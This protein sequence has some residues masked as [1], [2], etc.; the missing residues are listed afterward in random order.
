MRKALNRER[1]NV[2]RPAYTDRVKAILLASTDGGVEERLADALD[3]YRRGTQP[4][5][6]KWAV[7]SARACKIRNRSS[8]TVFVTAR[9]LENSAEIVDRARQ[10]GMAVTVVP[11]DVQGKI[12]WAKDESGGK[13]RDLNSYREEYGK[14]FEYKFVELE[15]LEDAERAVYDMG[16]DI[17][18]IAGVEM[19]N[20]QVLVSETMR[21][22]AIDSTR[23]VWDPGEGR[24]IVKRDVLS[25][26]AEYAGTLLHAA[27]RAAS[28]A[29][30][31]TRKFEEALTWLLG[32]VAIAAV[33][34]KAASD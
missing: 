26:E 8:R 34:A 22:R 19:E 13:V 29:P 5:E 2:G 17:L 16:P 4:D 23:G 14:S 7:I 32:N 20:V 18:K 28:G 9:Q 11:E 25:S 3:G 21:S 10:D 15:G 33:S 30:G 6:M 12:R 24:I 27:T 31:M 1:T